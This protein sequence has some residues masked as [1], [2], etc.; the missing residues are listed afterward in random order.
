[1]RKY[2]LFVAISFTALFSSCS[3]SNKTVSYA[4]DK[5][6]YDAL[7]KLSKKP[8]EPQLK[9]DVV[10][11]YNQAVQQHESR[12]SSYRTS[13]ELNRYDKILAEYNT[14]QRINESI[15]TSSA[16]REVSSRNYQTEIQSVK[17]EAAAALYNDAM[18]NLDEGTK[19]GARR[20]YEQF[21]KSRQ[22]VQ[23]YKDTD[24]MIKVAYESSIVN[25]L[26]NPI[27]NAFNGSWGNS[28]NVDPRF[29][30]MHQDLVRDLGGQTGNGS[31]RYFTDMDAR[32]L[33]IRPDWVID[34]NWSFMSSPP[35]ILNR[36]NRDLSKQIEVGKDTSGRPVYQTVSATLH[37]TRFQSL[38]NDIDYRIV[39]VESNRTL[40][41]NRIQTNNNAGVFETATFTGDSRALSSND[42][43]LVNNRQNGMQEQMVREM[44]NDLQR[45]LRS[46]IQARL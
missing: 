17:E 31:V 46:R 33:N 38:A 11:L 41:W 26:I 2:L 21:S 40:D 27:S 14:L 36:Y 43:N 29:M 30:Y 7:K 44:Y 18:R 34:I 15:R 9:K 37:V 5:A 25:I 13:M 24:R 22:Y 35:N 32:R 39:D 10:D 20:A 45:E 1:M 3:S 8:D 6:Y 4:E 16:F 28:W 12:I 42:W 19:Q 23:G